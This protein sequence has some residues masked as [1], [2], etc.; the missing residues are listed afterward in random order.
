MSKKKTVKKKKSIKKTAKKKSTQPEVTPYPTAGPKITNFE[1]KLDEQLTGE[2]PKRQRGRPRKDLL[3]INSA[4]IGPALEL[5]INFVK[6]P[7]ELW[8]IRE[9]EVEGLALTDAEA[10][11]IAEPARELI[12]YYLPMIPPIGYAWASLSVSFFWIIRNRLTAIEQVKTQKKAKYSA[13]TAAEQKDHKIKAH[14]SAG[15]SGQGIPVNELK[16]PKT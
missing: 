11:Q 5:V 14:G 16:N 4:P 10:K 6:L 8:Q 9:T 1:Q 2:P 15:P 12:E 7:F 3:Q 13:P